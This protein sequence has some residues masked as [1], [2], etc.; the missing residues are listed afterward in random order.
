MATIT[1]G[2]GL[3]A[4][5]QRLF[6]ALGIH[7]ERG[8]LVRTGRIEAQMATDVD[9]LAI[10]YTQ[11]FHRTIYHVECKGEKRA[12]TLD[13]VFW[14]S[15]VRSLLNADRSFLVMPSEDTRSSE[16]ARQLDVETL[17]LN[18][19]NEM[20][21]NYKIPD[22]WWPGRANYGFWDDLQPTRSKY[23]DMV[24][25]TEN[26]NTYLRDMYTL[27]FEEGWRG[28]PYGSLNKLLK[29]LKQI[30]EEVDVKTM[31]PIP[32][33]VVRMVISYGLVRFTHYLL[34]ACQDLLFRQP[35]ERPQFLADRLMFG[36]QDSRYMRLVTERSVGMIKSALA[37]QGVEPPPRWNTA[38]LQTPDYHEAL[39]ETVQRLLH[40][41]E[42]T[43]NLPLSMELIQFGFDSEP[44][45]V[46]QAIVDSGR[47]MVGIVKA[48]IAQGLEIHSSLL[49][50][51]D[52]AVL[53][54]YKR[55]HKHQKKNSKAITRKQGDLLGGTH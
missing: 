43:V 46:V 23:A 36:N 17:G 41:P 27:C 48:F 51:P 16:F 34:H 45:G 10:S 29:L 53:A 4:R 3:E 2:A 38:L 24:G 26:L 6:T 50:P 1:S 9:I 30:G 54:S 14:L 37:E 49:D 40:S 47:P 19:L 22:Q 21:D 8:L 35:L 18:M 32:L 20:E 42:Q 5:L 33:Q 44:R 25:L 7:S 11:D 28:A 13:R 12:K 52:I 15:G 31:P 39:L 55:S